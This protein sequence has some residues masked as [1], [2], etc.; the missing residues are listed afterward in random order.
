M[1]KLGV[2][3]GLGPMATAYFFQLVTQMSQAETDQEHIETII[4]S[5]PTIPDRTKYILNRN[6]KNP[7][8]DII[9][10]GNVLKASGAEV[11]AI[12]CI[13]A[14]FF[15]NEIE[16]ALE[17]PIIHAIEETAFYLKSRNITKIGIMATDGTIQ[18]EL[19]QKTFQDSGLQSVLPDEENQKKVM[20]IIYDNVK[21][22][23][24]VDMD[25]FKEISTYLFEQGAQVIV[26]GCT[27]LS[28]V[29]RDYKLPAG[30]L[31][32]LDV[33]AQSAVKK[34]GII[35]EEYIELIT[36]EEGEK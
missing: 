9:E 28:V 34:C 11:I 26:L 3:G 5:K 23:K 15:H 31:D 12:P 6:E 25:N 2:I 18:S 21:A 19:F 32:V 10:V 35:R 13:T 33:L 24:T 14:H 7:V 8:E 1:K 29:K 30:Y 27:E 16:N 36:M 22:G 20:S 17:L 4:Y